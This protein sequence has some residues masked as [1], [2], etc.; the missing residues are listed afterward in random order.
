MTICEQ[1]YCAVDMYIT[2][3]VAISLLKLSLFLYS[4]SVVATHGDQS[5]SDSE[6]VVPSE[7]ASAVQ[8]NETRSEDIQSGETK[9]AG[10]RT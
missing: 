2:S 1:Y 7:G 4:M 3:S 5:D 6:W 8:T 9:G 10:C